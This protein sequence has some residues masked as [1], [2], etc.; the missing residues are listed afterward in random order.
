MKTKTNKTKNLRR[1]ALAAALLLILALLLAFD[2]INGDPLSQQWAI[3][4]AIRY[5]ENTGT[6]P[7]E[8][9]T[10]MRKSYIRRKHFTGTSAPPLA[11][12]SST[13]W[14]TFSLTRAVI[15]TLQCR[16]GSGC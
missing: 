4:R 13:M 16:R 14:Y 5:A 15:Q 10:G 9:G 3:Y 6:W 2:A 12:S 7:D 8:E 11:D 1:L